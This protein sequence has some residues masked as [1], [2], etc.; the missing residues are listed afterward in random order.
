MIKIGDTVVFKGS[1]I[2]RCGHSREVAGMRGIVTEL[3]RD[4]PVATV[5]TDYGTTR[6]IPV[7]NLAKVKQGRILDLP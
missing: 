7:A 3:T 2:A 4:N 1:V 6:H 5:E